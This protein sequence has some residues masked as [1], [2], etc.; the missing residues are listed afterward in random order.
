MTLSTMTLQNDTQHNDTHENQNVIRMLYASE[1]Y[2]AEWPLRQM[3]IHLYN[4]YQ[5][6]IQYNDTHQ[7]DIRTLSIMTPIRMKL[8]RMTLKNFL[9]EETYHNG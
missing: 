6:D 1:C 7:N 5:N 3:T 9:N 8:S 2:E 4:T